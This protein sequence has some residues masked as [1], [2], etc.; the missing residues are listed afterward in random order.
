MFM[1]NMFINRL[2]ELGVLREFLKAEG[3]GLAVVY[4]RRRVGKTSLMLKLISEFGGFYLYTPASSDIKAVLESYWRTLP[5]PPGERSKWRGWRGFLSYLEV[6]GKS[7][8]LVVI[9]EFQRIQDAYKPAISILQEWWDLRLSKTKLKLILCGS[10]VG[11]IEK[12]AVEGSAPLYG[13]ADLQFKL[14][15][16]D[17][18]SA[19][20]FLK[21]L[22]ELE[23]LKVYSYLGG[24]P[25]YIE[26][27]NPNINL[28]ENLKRIV[29]YPGA[30]LLE[31]PY[32]ILLE[33]VR[34]IG[35]YNDIMRQLSGRGLPLSKI[36]A[37]RG[38]PMEYLKTLMRMDLVE[39]IVPPTEAGKARPKR[40]IYRISD[41]FFRFW[42]SMVYPNLDRIERWVDI[43]PILRR[44]TQHISI[45]M[46]QVASELAQHN[47]LTPNDKVVLAGPWWWKEEE[48]DCVAIGKRKTYIIE[49]KV[50]RVRVEDVRELAG[51]A[52]IFKQVEN[53]RRPVEKI[54]FTPGATSKA[55]EEAR[56]VKV[57]IIEINKLSRNLDQTEV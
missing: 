3:S 15:S 44:D 37:R 48:I 9:D 46:E 14:K 24:T 49:C 39:R 32:R 30:P 33:E 23:R 6:L 42:Y 57:K 43:T 38:S 16:M 27:Y 21:G 17:Y 36:K 45:T 34:A 2:R 50:G 29:L 11:M 51:K 31:E 7:G 4:G 54:L 41:P 5:P 12:I 55:Y 20:R 22:D 52:E 8:V 25:A 13:R 26:R 1:I 19:R 56:N 53:W 35:S 40:A 28:W 10:T 18:I 47:L